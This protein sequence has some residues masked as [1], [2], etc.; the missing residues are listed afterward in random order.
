MHRSESKRK[1]LKD[2]AVRHRAPT[3]YTAR[4]IT[5]VVGGMHNAFLFL[6]T[7]EKLL[8]RSESSTAK[9][10]RGAGM[11]CA[12]KKKPSAAGESGSHVASSQQRKLPSSSAP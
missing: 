2:D 10:Q 8:K 6:F 9:P 5:R 7:C 12:C 4:Q 1:E 11:L 3:L